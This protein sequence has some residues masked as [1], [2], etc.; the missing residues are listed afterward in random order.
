MKKSSIVLCLMLVSAFS[1]S[2]VKK[3]SIRNEI[4]F[5]ISDMLYSFVDNNFFPTINLSYKRVYNKNVF[6]SGITYNYSITDKYTP[7]INQSFSY[8][9]TNVGYER[10]FFDKKIQLLAGADLCYS[11][12]S[13]KVKF[14][15][16]FNYKYT[17]NKIGIGPVVGLIYNPTKRWSFQT[18]LGLFY[19]PCKEK[20]TR[21]GQSAWIN[22]GTFFSLQR[23]FSFNV[24]YKF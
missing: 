13:D 18:E 16:G 22:R 15:D 11:Y 19:G 23:T 4:G 1:F 2:Q 7:G 3:D 21:K 12:R 5:G 17:E 9:L 8:F 6:R 10:R 24:Y 14:D 20:W